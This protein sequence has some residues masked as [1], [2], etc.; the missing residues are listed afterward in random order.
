M[1]LKN[2]IWRML[3]VLSAGRR[4]KIT[5]WNLWE[6]YDK[7]TLKAEPVLVCVGDSVKITAEI[8][9]VNQYQNYWWS[10]NSNTY[11]NNLLIQKYQ[12]NKT[13]KF[14]ITFQ[15]DTNG[16]NKLSCPNTDS[17]FVYADSV[18]ADFD[19][20]S[21]LEPFYCFNNKWTYYCI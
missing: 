18:I 19:I 12:L 10:F 8:N 6:T 16:L 14:K 21:T 9:S 1:A 11:K 2:I 4:E 17:I 7:T 5:R 15:A 13:G 3:K 20:D